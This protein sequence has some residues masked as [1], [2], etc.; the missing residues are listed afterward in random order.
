MSDQ[1]LFRRTRLFRRLIAVCGLLFASLMS[2]SP[3]RAE[4]HQ[5]QFEKISIPKASAD[6]KTRSEVSLQAA[7]EYLE[8]GS[9]AWNGQ[10]KCVSCHTNGTY[11]TIRPALTKSLGAPGEST[12]AFFLEQLAKLSAEPNEKLR[13]STR[14]AQVIYIAAGLAEWDAAITGKLSEE[15]DKALQLM[16]AIQETSGTWGSL[17]CWPP[18]ESDAYHEATIAAMAAAA[19]P[20]W[21]EKVKSSSELKDTAAAVDRLKTYLKT[22]A[23]L[24]DYSRVLLLWT[25]SRMPDLLTEEQKKE[26][27][28]TVQKHQ[29]SDGSWS[30]RTFAVPEAWGGGNRAE[31]LKAEPDFAD[32]PGDGH[33]TGLAIIVLRSNGVPASDEKIQSGIRWLKS[34]QRESGRWWTRSLNTDSW[35]FITY[36][37][38]AYPLLALQMCDDPAVARK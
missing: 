29:K 22:Q 30:I 13:E 17:N 1:S 19:A 28:A 16:F 24:H 10:R 38:T 12:R 18:F 3:S 7:A 11:M 5:Y 2:S 6:E 15:T 35:H 25:A 33:M 8:N 34:N 32:P 9:L 31:K 27:I 14:P 26:L 21:L 23:P 4:D 36:S 20:G 37:G